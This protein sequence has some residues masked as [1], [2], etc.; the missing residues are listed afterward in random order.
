LLTLLAQAQ[1][2]GLIG[3]S[4]SERLTFLALAEHAKVVGSQNPCGLFAALVH[5]QHWH[6]VTDSD[7]EVAQTRLKAYLYG[8]ATR[9]APPP[10]RPH[11]LSIS[12]KTPP[13]CAMCTPNWPGPAGRAMPLAS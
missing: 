13:L 12:H 8:S 3:K 1:T 9:A 6:F 4:D 7:E 10:P 5:R 11:P 2:Q